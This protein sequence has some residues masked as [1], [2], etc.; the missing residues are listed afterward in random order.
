MS[1]LIIVT[2]AGSGIGRATARRFAESGDAVLLVGRRAQLLEEVAAQLRPSTE[3]SVQ[4]YPADL[5]D[6]MAV[7]GLRDHVAGMEH[8][9]TALVCCAGSAPQTTGNDLDAVAGEWLDSFN[10]NVMTSVLPVHS[11]TPLLADH[12]SIVLVSSIAAYRGSGGS[13]AYG[14]AKAAIHSYAHTLATSLGPRG[15][16]VNVIAP[17]YVSGTELFGDAMSEARE[18]ML[19]RQTLLRRAGVPDDVAGLAHFLCSPQGAYITSQIVQIN[20]GSLPGV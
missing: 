15:I 10:T 14:A 1:R 18:T 17:G 5:A 9:L 11:L 13:G 8:P 7:L 20:G 19:I 3:A 16:N 6:P 2:G 4:T 12:G